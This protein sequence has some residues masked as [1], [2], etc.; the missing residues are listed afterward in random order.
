MQYVQ[1]W[2]H[3]IGATPTNFINSFIPPSLYVTLLIVISSSKL[4]PLCVDFVIY[5]R[6]RFH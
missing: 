6:N 2:K 3:N 1:S 5:T 4:T